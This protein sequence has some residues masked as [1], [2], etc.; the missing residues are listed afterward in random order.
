MRLVTIILLHV[1]IL[2][3]LQMREFEQLNASKQSA[4]LLVTRLTL[5]WSKEQVGLGH[6]SVRIWGSEGEACL[7]PKAYVRT[8]PGTWGQ[9]GISRLHELHTNRLVQGAT[10]SGG[11]RR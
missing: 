8:K 6:A 7:K 5:G 1:D 10:A 3:C 11:Q 9:I 2:W 4:D